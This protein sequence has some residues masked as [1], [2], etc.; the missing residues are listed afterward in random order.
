MA[1][2]TVVHPYYDGRFNGMPMGVVYVATALKNRGHEVIINDLNSKKVSNSEFRQLIEE[3]N[4]EYVGIASTS[5]THLDACHIASL[6]K[7][8][9]DIP[10]IKGGT[11]ETYCAE[12]TL[13][14]HPEIDI[15][16]LGPG[17]ETIVDL[18]ESLERGED[19]RHVSGI[20]FR[21][22]N[23][24]ISTKPRSLR[25]A[26]DEYPHPD[27]TL[28]E[29][30]EFYDFNIFNGK[31]TQIRMSRGCSYG[32]NFCP[33]DR[34]YK[35]HS[36][37]YVLEELRQI[38]EE[39]YKSI[40]WDDAIFTA[41]KKTASEV[42]R[43][44]ISEGFDFQMG[45]QTRADVN[46]DENML[47]LMREAG[48]NYVSFGLESGDQDL[49]AR[50]NKRL[51]VEDVRN[52]VKLSKDRGINT[53]LTAII[54]SPDELRDFDPLKR[55]VEA[56]NDIQPD[57]VSWSVYS[58]YPGSS[59]EFDPR[60]YE[61]PEELSLDPVF[62]QFDEGYKAKTLVTPEYVRNAQELIVTNL[63]NRINI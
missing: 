14:F 3:Q 29:P 44:I 22:D 20:A 61:T 27:R 24:I 63:D 34:T 6:V 16:I 52:A 57:S 9:I 54:G 33:I 60:W 48:F 49:L 47:N 41:H 23:N 18:I 37:D 59:L 12:T 19:L 13:K 5:P 8:T 43:R 15:S 35:F 45:A 50:Y 62:Q 17:E 39:G 46:I 42:L 56:I 2:V 11:H 7:E 31:T 1:R 55:T 10:V 25:S 30:S 21:N 32:C 28:L 53:S 38:E 36:A 58:I 4:P 51:N 26:L 40:F